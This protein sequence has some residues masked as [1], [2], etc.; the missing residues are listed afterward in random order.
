MVE[1]NRT[2]RSAVQTLLVAAAV[3]AML[4]LAALAVP[5]SPFAVPAYAM[6][7][8]PA[9]TTEANPD[10]AAG[11]KAI[12]D[13]DWKGA[14]AALTKAA[15]AMPKDA[16]VQNYLG[17]AYRNAGNFDQAFAHYAVALKLDPKH[18]GAHEY[19]G[20][21]YLLQGDLPKA[22]AQLKILDDLCTFGCAEYS[23]LKSKIA[24]YRQQHAK[25]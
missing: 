20:E 24:A 13:K 2:G 11:K 23:E 3:P 15:A 22:E 7:G 6:G 1:R 25:G 8:D 19:M 21:A 5:A 10:F 9:P 18:R 17:Y 14:I 4:A 16:D 12:A